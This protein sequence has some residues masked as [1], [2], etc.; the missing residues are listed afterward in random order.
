MTTNL[1][2]DL[3]KSELPLYTAL[4][5]SNLAWLP[6]ATGIAKLETDLAV[7]FTALGQPSDKYL[8]KLAIQKNNTL[9]SICH[10]S[11]IAVAAIVMIFLVRKGTDPRL[12]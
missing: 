1:W 9:F 2:S 8:N 5:M 7:G 6:S 11:N 10:T 3:Y 4:Q 12:F